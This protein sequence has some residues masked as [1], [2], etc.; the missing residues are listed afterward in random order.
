M[1]NIN[2]FVEIK[3]DASEFNKIN[4]TLDQKLSAYRAAIEICGR[5][6]LINPSL[7]KQEQFDQGMDEY[8]LQLKN[9]SRLVL[10]EANRL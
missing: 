1:A 7:D 2:N 3:I 10:L 9:V 8:F 5:P 6:V 4:P